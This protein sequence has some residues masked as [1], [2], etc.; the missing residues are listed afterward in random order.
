MPNLGGHDLYVFNRD[1]QDFKLTF[2]D[3]EYIESRRF[4]NNL[5]SSNTKQLFDSIMTSIWTCNRYSVKS[6]T[7]DTYII[8]DTNLQDFIDNCPSPFW[9]LVPQTV[10]LS[11]VSFHP[12]NCN[13]CRWNILLEFV[14]ATEFKY[15]QSPSTSTPKN[16]STTI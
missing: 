12:Y 14:S 13:D 11:A 15:N 4:L 1:G 8:G 3:C 9:S 5:T 10:C 6:K 2:G 16:S 7:Y